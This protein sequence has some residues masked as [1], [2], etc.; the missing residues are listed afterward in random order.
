MPIFDDLKC[1]NCM[2]WC[3][4]YGWPNFF[5][6]MAEHY[7]ENSNPGSD[8]GQQ[9]K[10]QER[11]Y[12]CYNLSYNYFFNMHICGEVYFILIYLIIIFLK[13]ITM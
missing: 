9:K 7:K 12:F 8:C 11:C 4:E 3:M 13:N 10:M 1:I 2:P 6:T 5:L